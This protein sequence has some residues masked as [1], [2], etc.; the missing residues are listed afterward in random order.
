LTAAISGADD[1]DDCTSFDVLDTARCIGTEAYVMWISDDQGPRW[2]SNI[3]L[4]WSESADGTAKLSGSVAAINNPSDIYVVGAIFTGKTTEAPSG[5]PKSHLCNDENIEGWEYYTSMFGIISSA[6]GSWSIDIMRRGAAFQVG[7]GANDSEKEIGVPGGSGWFIAANDVTTIG[8]FNFIKGAC[9]TLGT[10]S[11]VEY[12]WS[13]GETTPSITVTDSDTYSVVVTGCGGCEGFDDV[14]IDFNGGEVIADAGEDVQA[15]ILPSSIFPA[16]AE[17]TATG[18]DRYLWSTG[19]TTASITVFTRVTTSYTVTAFKGAC[20]DTDD[21]LVTVVICNGGVLQKAMK[22]V[23]YPIPQAADQGAITVEVNNT[24]G[25]KSMMTF[26]LYD[27]SGKVIDRLDSK[28]ME[29]GRNKMQLAIPK[30]SPGIYLL[31]MMNT[32]NSDSDF[33]RLIIE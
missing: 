15:C 30:L 17:L 31:E 29:L 16:G 27:I 4:V 14:V 23:L 21:V 8:D 18:G 13:T 6:D 11:S 12:L 19:E 28:E 22:A 33:T 3:D 1:C 20:S 25:A 5:S 32:T 26:E 7:N 2:F 9:K 24:V 10:A